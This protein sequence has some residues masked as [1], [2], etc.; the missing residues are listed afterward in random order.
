LRVPDG[1]PLLGV[2]RTFVVIGAPL[3]VE[4]PPR[5]DGPTKI[6][7]SP[8]PREE[9]CFPEDRNAFHRIEREGSGFCGRIAPSGLR[10][11]S[12][13]HAAHTVSS[14]EEGVFDGH[15]KVTVRSPADP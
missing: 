13:A 2:R 1:V 6:R 4:E 5:P 3:V 12:P 10:A 8:G 11:G 14:K 9:H 7:V 15:C